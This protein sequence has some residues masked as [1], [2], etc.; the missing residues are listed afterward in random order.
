[1][2]RP[3]TIE[4]AKANHPH[5]NLRA[6]HEKFHNHWPAQPGQKGVKADWDRTWRNWIIRASEHT[7]TRLPAASGMSR[8]EQKIA[9]AERFKANPN[10][11]LLS[12]AGFD[13]RPGLTAL[14]GGI[15]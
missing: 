3:D 11:E 10:T 13:T 7:T 9:A 8:R 4:W 5:V 14:P 6:E 2:P 15:Q 1:M 12:R